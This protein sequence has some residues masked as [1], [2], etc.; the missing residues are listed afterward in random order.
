MAQNPGPAGSAHAYD[1]P[2]DNQI[3][4][5]YGNT[6]AA[7]GR[8]NP[9][10]HSDPQSTANPSYG[11]AQTHSS[12]YETAGANPSQGPSSTGPGGSLSGNYHDRVDETYG[13]ATGPSTTGASGTT[14]GAGAT[15]PYEEAGANSS[16][17]GSAGEG[18]G[19]GGQVKQGASGVKG[20]LAAVHGAGESIRGQ[21]NAGVDR[22]FNEV[23]E[24][25]LFPDLHSLVPFSGE[26]DGD[27]E[28]ETPVV[29]SSSPDPP[30][31]LRNEVSGEEGAEEGND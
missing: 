20:V 18:A 5:S 17:G 29:V 10:Q 21:L 11:K 28:I 23:C 13:H 31:R 16:Q 1:A 30:P 8:A 19:V 9:L 6:H 2:G 26:E 25:V 24:P 22:A 7:S 27:D 12:P 3:A 4:G 15:G 14:S